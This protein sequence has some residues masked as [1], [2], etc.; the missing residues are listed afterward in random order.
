MHG[1]VFQQIAFAASGSADSVLVVLSMRGGC[2]GLSLVVPYGDD[3]YYQARR[4]IGIPKGA[5]LVPDGFFGLHPQLSPLVPMWKAGQM[6]AV[7]ATGLPAPNRSH[8]SAMEEVEDADPGSG[9][10]VGWL[11]RMVGMTEPDSLFPAVQIGSGVPHTQIYGPQPTLAAPDVDKIAIYGP[12]GAMGARRAGLDITWNA[13]DGPLGQAARDALITADEWAP[14][15]D[16]PGDPQHGAQYPKGDLGEALAQSARV[17]RADVGAQVVT[18]DHGSWDMHTD[19]GT[20]DWGQMR[21]MVDELALAVQAFFQDLGDLSSKVTL[22][23]ISEFGRRVAEN[24]DAGLDHGYGNAMFVMG[25]GVKGGSV[26]GTWPWLDPRHLDGGDLHVTTDYR[27]VLAEIVRMRF[28][29]VD[30][31]QL[32]PNFSPEYVGVMQGA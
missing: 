26:Y 28:S 6:A 23:T 17:I 11:N 7:H 12:K 20:L 5:L 10:R 27:S 29:G 31:S 4:V 19:L 30:M 16:L 9:V 1:T 21:V 22:V 18:V 13:A 15:R 25:A 2:D 32:F 14:V 3:A 24:G 8:F